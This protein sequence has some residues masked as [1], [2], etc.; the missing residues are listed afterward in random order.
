MQNIK[1]I[2]ITCLESQR[3]VTLSNQIQNNI[4]NALH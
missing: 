2:N 3:Q 1:H 4:N